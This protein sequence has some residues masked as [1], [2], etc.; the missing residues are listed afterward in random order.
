MTFKGLGTFQMVSEHSLQVTSCITTNK[1]VSLSF[2]ALKAGIDFSLTTKVLDG[3]FQYNLVLLT[4]KICC[5]VL[6]TV[7]HYHRS[8]RLLAAASINTS[9]LAASPGSYFMEAASFLQPYE[10]DLMATD[11]YCSLLT[12]CSL[13]RI[14]WLTRLT[15]EY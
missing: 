1:R 15:I 9:A 12:S 5:L 10:P 13:H 2:E 7:I 8:S 3:T 6:P 11:Y 4:L 14:E